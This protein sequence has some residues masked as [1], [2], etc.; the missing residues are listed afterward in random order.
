VPFADFNCLLL[1]PDSVEKENDY[2]MLADIF[3]TGWHGTRLAG[4]TAGDT[5]AV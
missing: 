5:V 4:V 1:P 2:V 3:P